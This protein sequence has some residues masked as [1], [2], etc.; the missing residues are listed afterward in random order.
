MKKILLLGICLIALTGIASAFINGGFSPTNPAGDDA[1]SG[2]MYLTG[3]GVDGSV[4]L[5]EASTGVKYSFEGEGGMYSTGDPTEGGYYPE[6]AGDEIGDPYFQ[7]VDEGTP[8]TGPE[9]DEMSIG[10]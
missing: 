3:A 6:G 8:T 5:S 4:Y 10:G 9:T 7:P 2:N 1:T